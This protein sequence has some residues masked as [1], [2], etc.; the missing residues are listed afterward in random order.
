MKRPAPVLKGLG[1]LLAVLAVMIPATTAFGFQQDEVP[2]AF[3]GAMLGIMLLVFAVFY[4]YSSLALQTIAKKTN[5]EN[6]WLAW[7]PIA[8]VILMLN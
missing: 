8:N 7:I 1:S 3:L 5:T 2:T 6:A 4:V